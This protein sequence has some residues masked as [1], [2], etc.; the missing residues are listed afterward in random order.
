MYTSFGGDNST[1]LSGCPLNNWLSKAFTEKGAECYLEFLGENITSSCTNCNC[2][3]DVFHHHSENFVTCFW[4]N[5]TAGRSIR[6]ATL[7]ADDCDS[8]EMNPRLVERY[9]GACN[10]TLIKRGA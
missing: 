5:I 2:N 1:T 4:A 7:A 6:N 9:P 10:Q 8:P 3:S